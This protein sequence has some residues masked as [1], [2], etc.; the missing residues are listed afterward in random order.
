M[1]PNPKLPDILLFLYEVFWTRI[2]MFIEG[3]KD[4]ARNFFRKAIQMN[5]QDEDTFEF[6]R[7]RF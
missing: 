2:F 5:S 1:P 7:L 4:E 3:R 6:S